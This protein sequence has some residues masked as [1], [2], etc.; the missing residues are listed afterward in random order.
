M[1]L[2]QRD[3]NLT[4]YCI[5]VLIQCNLLDIFYELIQKFCY[6]DNYIFILKETSW[7][8]R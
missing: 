7:R 6:Y 4:E 3:T 1:V 8:T 5:Y 2:I